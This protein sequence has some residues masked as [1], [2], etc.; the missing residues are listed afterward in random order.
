MYKYISNLQYD[1]T[2]Y[3]L[4]TIYY[5]VVTK[6]QIDISTIIRIIFHYTAGVI[7][8]QVIDPLRRLHI[9]LNPAMGIT[10]C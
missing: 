1:N 8:I 4:S 2:I 9:G 5:G 3:L 7:R 10:L 6:L